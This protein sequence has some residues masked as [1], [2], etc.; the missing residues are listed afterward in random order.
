MPRCV[1]GFVA[2]LHRRRHA[3]LDLKLVL[4]GGVPTQLA[5]QLITQGLAGGALQRLTIVTNVL[6]LAAPL[7]Q[8]LTLSAGWLGCLPNLERLNVT[9]DELAFSPSFEQLAGLRS[10]AMHAGSEYFV[11]SHLPPQLRELVLC[12][13]DARAIPWCVSSLH[14]LERLAVECTGEQHP[15][16]DYDY[17]SDDEMTWPHEEP[18]ELEGIAALT[19][20]TLLKLGKSTVR[21]NLP[22]ELG[23]ATGLR[24]LRLERLELA[25]TMAPLRELSAL[26]ELTLAGCTV[27][28]G[29]SIPNIEV[30]TDGRLKV[31]ASITGIGCVAK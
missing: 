6:G 19:A 13:V 21:G 17:Y 2:W 26:S 28:G 16:N 24:T 14:S 12:S 20:L 23:A 1:E 8:P 22:R 11:P 27:D 15:P 29:V 7:K 3:I 9:C 31:R 10:L 4:P 25:G 5:S 30:L 18:L